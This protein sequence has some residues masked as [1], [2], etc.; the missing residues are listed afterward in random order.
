[1]SKQLALILWLGL[2]VYGLP[3]QLQDRYVLASTGAVH[4]STNVGGFSLN[5]DW[6]L[7]EVAVATGFGG[8]IVLTQGFQQPYSVVT[9]L[10]EPAPLTLSYEIY[11]N[12]TRDRL[13]VEI[14]SDRPIGVTA[15]WTDRAGKAIA[16]P[17]QQVRVSGSA[18]MSFD[19]S[20]LAEGYYHLSLRDEDGQAI[21][22]FTIQRLDR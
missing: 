18:S 3:A 19:L 13:Y 10:E 21:R 12:P 17:D 5:L 4:D 11:P 7:G 2:A 22:S 8:T 14:S 1:M 20:R 16:I 6:T 15:T 9:G